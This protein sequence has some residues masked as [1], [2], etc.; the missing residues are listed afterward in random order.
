MT[1]I[2]A[3]EPL[4]GTWYVETLLGEGGF[5]KVYK[6]RR[7][8][9]GKTYYSAVKII[10]IPHDEGELRQLKNEGLDDASMRQ[11]LYAF[12]TDIISE[13][14]LMRQ[15]RGTSHIVSLEDHQIIPKTTSHNSIG[16]D[17]LIRMELLTSLS[18]H[19][20]QSPL[21]KADIVKL[22]IHICRALELCARTNT[23]H[24]DIKPENIFVSPYGD[25]KLGDF[26]IARQL[27][28][29]SAGLSKK[30]TY[31]YMAPEV[32]RG[33]QYG[34][35]VDTYSL[36]LVLYRFL[37]QNRTPFMPDYP[38]P[39]MPSDRDTAIEK[40]LSGVP[41]PLLKGV[42][43]EL[44]GVVLKAC[45]FNSKGRFTSPTEMRE[46]LE[47]IE[48]TQNYEAAAAEAPGPLNLSD[49]DQT[50]AIPGQSQRHMTPTPSPYT[51]P[52]QSYTPN[53]PGQPYTTPPGQGY[54]PTPPGQSPFTP[55]HTLP[56]PT[57]AQYGTPAMPGSH[58]PYITPPPK[59]TKLPLIIALSSVA[60]IVLIVSITLIVIFSSSTPKLAG[61]AL[62]SQNLTNATLA[63]LVEKGNIPKDIQ[64]LDLS[65]NAIS[66]ITPLKSL[67]NLQTLNL[68]NNQIKDLTPLAGLTQLTELNLG[69][70]SLD[71]SSLQS[72]EPLKRL[73]KLSLNNN[74]SISA[75]TSLAKLSGL[76]E[77]NLDGIPLDDITP[78][79]S[80]SKIKTLYV[81]ELKTDKIWQLKTDLPQCQIQPAPPG[82]KTLTADECQNKLQGLDYVSWK[83]Q[84]WDITDQLTT[85][86]GVVKGIANGY[87]NIH[88]E[89]HEYATVENCTAIFNANK[90]NKVIVES[91]GG[92]ALLDINTENYQKYVYLTSDTDTYCVVVQVQTAFIWSTCDKAESETL[93]KILSDLGY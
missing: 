89:F 31:T 4:W 37:N 73:S 44:N 15:F 9:F 47:R 11:F 57:Q 25:F 46:A 54:T 29:T 56:Q 8:E 48:K 62:S 45:A 30:G 55:P 63:S 49:P 88:V 79:K 60:A 64:T 27:E 26:G 10:S 52:G 22:G 86:I 61:G 68:N 58:Q 19:A 16:W 72:L 13:I 41:M 67:T 51:A 20:A 34:S 93:D 69:R 71:N 17:I 70:N 28:R 18:D 24:R 82:K 32:F 91:T 66:D 40:R 76:E 84:Q 90:K 87:G 65:N 50:Y 12:V 21:A 36:G 39:I 59:S 83:Y 75:I 7:E 35:S 78:L 81:S 14:D 2:K 85:H 5:G 3:Y 77:L 80:L 74:S 42:S 33:E 92:S 6:V 1:D 38:Q 23:I 43:P 53:T